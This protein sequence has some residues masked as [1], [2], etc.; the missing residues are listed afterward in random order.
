MALRS[1]TTKAPVRLGP[2]L[3]PQTAGASDPSF[4]FGDDEAWMAMRFATGPATL[5]FRGAGRQIDAEAWGEGAAEALERAPGII[6]AEDDPAGFEPGPG[7]LR[8]LD[9]RHPG[10]RITRSG[11]VADMLIRSAVGQVVTGKEA[12]SSYRRLVAHLGEPAPGP[13]DLLLPPDPQVLA[14][15]AYHRYHP[16]GIERKRAATIIRI[17][18]HANR[19]DEA[20]GMPL[21]KAYR[22]IRAVPGVGP[23]TAALAGLTALGDADAVPVGDDNLPNSVAWLLAGEPRASDERMLEILAPYAG[24][25]GRVIRLVKASKEKAPRFGPRRQLRSIEGI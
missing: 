3:A 11:A 9:R 20:S 25:R 16:F 21:A 19:M 22:R 18:G 13:T 6:G 12:R 23:W 1:I 5:Y 2:T 8:D 7:V 15:M 24:H 14:A 4:R 10:I 17:A